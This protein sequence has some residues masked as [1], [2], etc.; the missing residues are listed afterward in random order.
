MGLGAK[1]LDK[2]FMWFYVGCYVGLVSGALGL[3]CGVSVSGLKGHSCWEVV[4]CLGS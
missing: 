3:R 1:G 2:L 4:F